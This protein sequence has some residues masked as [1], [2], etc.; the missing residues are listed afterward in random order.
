MILDVVHF[1]DLALTVGYDIAH[2]KHLL[3]KLRD[4]GGMHT[5]GFLRSAETR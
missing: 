1:F 5:N 4:S 3:S 2:G